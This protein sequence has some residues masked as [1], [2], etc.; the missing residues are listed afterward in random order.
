MD[1][2]RKNQSKTNHLEQWKKHQTFR[3]GSALMR[4][5]LPIVFA[6]GRRLPMISAMTSFLRDEAGITS[7]EYGLIAAIIV[8]AT[9]CAVSAAGFSLA[10]ITGLAQS[11]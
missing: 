5:T 10:D 3:L 8:V 1:F 11:Q 6:S 2:K 4:Q 9:T 7:I